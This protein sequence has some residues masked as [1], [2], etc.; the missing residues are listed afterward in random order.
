MS[1]N[2]FITNLLNIKDDNLTFLDGIHHKLIK[3]VNYSVVNAK[4]KYSNEP[5]PH[6]GCKDESLIIKY[7]FKLSHVRFSK[8]GDYPLIIDLKK[9]KMF[10]KKCGH[11]FIVSSNL[12]DKFSCISNQL[13]KSIFSDLTRKLPM[14][15]IA[16]DNF[17]SS[18]TVARILAKFDNS[19]NVDF[20][21]LPKHLCFDEFKSTRD[22]KGAMSFIFCDAD[23]HKIIDIVENRQLLFLKRYFYSFTKSVRDKVESICIDIYSPYISLIKDLFVN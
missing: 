7:G 15:D 17:V 23:N 6:C 10:C 12:V 9:Q 20:N 1:I 18:N 5:C 21:I 13:K 16:F 11:Y 3:G 14:K 22:A 4:L 2:Y 19:F 8:V